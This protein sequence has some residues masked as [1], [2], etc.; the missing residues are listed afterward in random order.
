MKFIL[1]GDEHTVL[2]Y[3]LIGI[4]GVVVKNAQEA[5][6]AL[7]SASKDSEIGVILITQRIASLIQYEVNNARLAMS[8]PVV[9]EI[10]DRQGPLEDKESAMNI[11]QRLIG[12][13]V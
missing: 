2:G 1:I 5:L 3:S 13:K 4:Q 7:N 9:L 8:I 10:P 12:I 11:I 6:D